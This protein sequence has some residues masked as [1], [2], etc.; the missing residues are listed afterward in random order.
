[1]WSSTASDLLLRHVFLDTNA[2]ADLW[3]FNPRGIVPPVSMVLAGTVTMDRATACVRHC[4]PRTLHLGLHICDP[5]P[6]ELLFM[7]HV[8]GNAP[9]PT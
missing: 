7:D 1:M 6:V 3:R 5:F 4:G 9:E 8:A 2:N